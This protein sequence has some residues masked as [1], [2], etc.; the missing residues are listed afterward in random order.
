MNKILA[1]P[2]LKA[3]IA[4]LVVYLV[5]GTTFGAIRI[6][7]EDIPPALLICLRF[8]LAGLLAIGFCLAR[9]EKLPG[10]EDLKTHLIIGFLLFF[11]GNSLVAWAVQ[12]IPTGFGGMIT[13]TSPFWMIWMASMLPPREKIQPMAIVGML[14]GFSGMLVLFFPQLNQPNTL[15]PEFWLSVVA[16][17]IMVFFW[18]AGSIYAR[19]KATKTSLLMSVGFQNIFA[20]LMLMP[21]C[22]FTVDP[23]QINLTSNVFGVL[24]YLVFMGTIV[25]TPCYIYVLRN[26]PVP[27]SS[28]FA[29]VTPMVTVLFGWLFLGEQI[30]FAT[31]LGAG[32]ILSGVVLVQWASQRSMSYRLSTSS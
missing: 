20:G 21:I 9:R 13:A 25:T 7:V 2:N 22:I 28:T 10:W 6:G 31:T 11:G 1:I 15:A 23:L 29:Y 27:V 5:W 26:L 16:M 32:I 14:I 8:T 12:H 17:F 18:S 30:T 19:K 4:L 3:Y 24:A